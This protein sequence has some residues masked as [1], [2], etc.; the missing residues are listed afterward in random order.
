MVGLTPLSEALRLLREYNRLVKRLSATCPLGDTPRGPEAL[1]R[2]SDAYNGLFIVD[3]A[4]RA[5]LDEVTDPVQSL[6]VV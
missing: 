3:A 4:S 1:K 2:W 6:R 5:F